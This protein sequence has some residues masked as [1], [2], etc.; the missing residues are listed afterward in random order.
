MSEFEKSGLRPATFCRSQGLALSIL[1]RHKWRRLENGQA[2]VWGEHNQAT[3]NRLVAVEL[4]RRDLDGN[5]RPT[6]ALKIVLSSSR[7]IEVEP[8]FG[9]ET[10]ARLVRILERL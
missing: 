7:Q 4:A 5:S 6:C 9:S 1:Q 3:N 2:K 10:L 8:D